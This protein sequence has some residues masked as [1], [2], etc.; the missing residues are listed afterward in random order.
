MTEQTGTIAE[1]FYRFENG[2]LTKCPPPSWYLKAM[3]EGEA[4]WHQALSDAGARAI[5]SFGDT[6]T[7]SVF[8]TPTG[9]HLVEY[10]DVEELVASVLID[11]A[12]DYLTF[13]A[14]FVAPLVSLIAAGDLEAQAEI[15][16][17]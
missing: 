12:G 14:K 10:I 15:R 11:D 5:E 9:G 13:R 8:K 3:D 6:D 7:L 17:H 2:R 16:E 4:D 1:K